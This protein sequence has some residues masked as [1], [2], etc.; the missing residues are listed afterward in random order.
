MAK[1]TVNLASEKVGWAYSE[2]R[3]MSF[4]G[5]EKRCRSYNAKTPEGFELRAYERPSFEG[6]TAQVLGTDGSLMSSSDGMDSAVAAA[7]RCERTAAQFAAEGAFTKTQLDAIDGT[8]LSD[9][10]SRAIAA[11]SAAPNPIP[12]PRALPGR[13]SAERA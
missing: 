12:R 7:L 11:C 4:S 8:R 6:W 13:D 2:A 1:D 3:D 9:R 10:A 5:S